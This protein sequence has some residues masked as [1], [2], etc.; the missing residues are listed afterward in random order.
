MILAGDFGMAFEI[1]THAFQNGATIPTRYTCEGADLS[2]DLSW[3]NPPEQTKSFAL[4]CDDPD[5]P[6]GT[7]VHWVIY[8]IPKE[9]QSLA[10]GVVTIDRLPDG[11]EQGLNDFKQSGYA[12]PCPPPGKAHRYFFKLYALD[13]VLSLKKDATKA[14][15]ERAMN[16]HILDKTELM[17]RYEKIGK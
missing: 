5:A 11:T 10:E 2:P 16:G 8:N 7:W 12:G 6:H 1:E 15:L 3:K 17:G 14:D 9:I 4:I 13:T